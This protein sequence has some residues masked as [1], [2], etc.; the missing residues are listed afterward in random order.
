MSKFYKDAESIAVFQIA[1][2]ATLF[3]VAIGMIVFTYLYGH[4]R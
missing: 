2:I 3:L 4:K 1:A